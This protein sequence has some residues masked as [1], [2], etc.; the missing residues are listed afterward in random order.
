MAQDLLKS[1]TPLAHSNE[2]G[3]IKRTSSNQNRPIDI[4]NQP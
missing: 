1:E 3:S 4:A 2:F